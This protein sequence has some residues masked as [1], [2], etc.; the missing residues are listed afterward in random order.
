MS[1]TNK[2]KRLISQL[3][4][5]S[6]PEKVK[7]TL[8]T[9]FRNNA[10]PGTSVRI[11]DP[12]DIDYF[13]EDGPAPTW[14]MS[15]GTDGPEDMDEFFW[16]SVYQKG[17]NEIYATYQAPA[18]YAPG[19]GPIPLIVNG[20]ENPDLLKY[21]TQDPSKP[22]QLINLMGQEFWGFPDAVEDDGGED[23]M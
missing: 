9:F 1:T 3:L 12:R 2:A 10:K 6:T 4:G 15:V 19:I 8:Q 7:Q 11:N 23:D 22:K 20:Q 17:T 5:E 14:V 16:L 21:F 13:S 18:Q